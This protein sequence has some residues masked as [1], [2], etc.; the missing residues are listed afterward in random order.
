MT[1]NTMRLY[2]KPVSY[3][4]IVGG[5]LMLTDDAGQAQFMVMFRGTTQGISKKQNDALTRQIAEMI[6]QHGLEVPAHD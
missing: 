4:S 6:A 2:A 5:G 1:D 3:S